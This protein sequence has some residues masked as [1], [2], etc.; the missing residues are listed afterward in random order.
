MKDDPGTKNTPYIRDDDNLRD[1][2]AR[3]LKAFL[4]M[5]A[6][7]QIARGRWAGTKTVRGQLCIATGNTW[8]PKREPKMEVGGKKVALTIGYKGTSQE[9]FDNMVAQRL[10]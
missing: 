4:D 5:Q 6:K 1:I 10:H 2:S 3:I 8:D 7:E 9:E